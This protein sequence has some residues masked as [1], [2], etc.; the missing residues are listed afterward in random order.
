MP[1]LHKD[2]KRV[3]ISEEEIAARVNELAAQLSADYT[4]ARHL[5]LIG[6]VLTH[7]VLIVLQRLV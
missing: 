2:L 4:D 3:L 1:E 5:Y 7:L 6:I